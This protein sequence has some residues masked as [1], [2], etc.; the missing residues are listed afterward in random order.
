MILEFK[1]TKNNNAIAN[2]ERN[3]EMLQEKIKNKMQRQGSKNAKS[4]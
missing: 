3:I 4:T 1:R 2:M